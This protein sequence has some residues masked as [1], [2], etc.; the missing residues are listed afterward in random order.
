[1]QSAWELPCCSRWW[2]T[3]SYLKAATSVGCSEHAACSRQP[4]VKCFVVSTNAFRL[5]PSVNGPSEACARGSGC[6][7]ESTAI[8]C[9]SWR[10]IGVS[11]SHPVECSRRRAPIPTTS[12]SAG[13]AS[14]PNGLKQASAGWG[15]SPMTFRVGHGVYRRPENRYSQLRAVKVRAIGRLRT[16]ASGAY[17]YGRQPLAHRGDITWTLTPCS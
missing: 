1:M 5:A 14:G 12:G 11:V 10:S 3:A 7:P 15:L 16:C 13:A 4:S 6:L 2:S 17:A 8:V 9:G